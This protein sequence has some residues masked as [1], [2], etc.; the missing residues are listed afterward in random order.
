[1][2][3]EPQGHDREHD[4]EADSSPPTA[5]LGRRLIRHRV[6][7]GQGPYHRVVTSVGLIVAGRALCRSEPRVSLG[8][9]YSI[10]AEVVY[11]FSCGVGKFQRWFGHACEVVALVID[12]NARQFTVPDVHLKLAGTCGRRQFQRLDDLVAGSPIGELTGP[13][14]DADLMVLQLETDQGT[15]GGVRATQQY[16][17][18]DV[19][20][21]TVRGIHGLMI[22]EYSRQ[23][24]PAGAVVRR[25]PG[26]D[27]V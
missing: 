19:I 4:F 1:M 27:Q 2:K 14:A 26:L 11:R 9:R 24:G 25:D 16:S 15:T 5:P 3:E 21:R 10:A 18:Q 6:G 20:A 8:E 17:L 23:F 13:H 12:K 22:K 7:V